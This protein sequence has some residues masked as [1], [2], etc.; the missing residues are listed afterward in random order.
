M[1]T[2]PQWDVGW[3]RIVLGPERKATA[4]VATKKQV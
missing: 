1:K 2:K 4:A 3:F